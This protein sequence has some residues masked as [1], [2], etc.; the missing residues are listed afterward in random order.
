LTALFL[1]ALAA[2]AVATSPRNGAVDAT[3]SAVVTVNY[4]E[5]VNPGTVNNGTFP[6]YSSLRGRLA[7]SYAVNGSTV[8]FDPDDILLPGETVLAVATSGME[9]GGGSAVEAWSWRFTAAA[10]PGPGSFNQTGD[11]NPAAAPIQ[12]I[13]A[14]DVNGDG[15]VD[16]AAANDLLPATQNVVYLNDGTGGF[17]STKN[18]GSGVDETRAVALADVDRDGDLDAVTGNRSG[19]PNVVYLNDGAGNFTAGQR[20]FGQSADNIMDLAVAD[21]DNN[22][23]LDLIAARA[24]QPGKVYTSTDG[25]FGSGVEIGLASWGTVAVD[26]GDFDGDGDADLVLA[27][28]SSSYRNVVL[29]NNGAAAF[30]TTLS[31][32]HSSDDTRGVKFLDADQD[33]RLDIAM[34]NYGLQNRVY[35]NDGAGGVLPASLNFGTGTDHTVALVVADFNGDGYPDIGLGNRDQQN[36]VYFYDSILGYSDDANFGPADDITLGLAAADIDRDGDLDLLA[37][38]YNQQSKSYLNGGFDLFPPAVAKSG[39]SVAPY[40]TGSVVTWTITARQNGPTGDLSISDTLGPDFNYLSHSATPELTAITTGAT[41]S[42]YWPQVALGETVT[43]TLVTEL[44]GA[45]ATTPTN[46]VVFTTT[47]YLTETETTPSQ[48]QCGGQPCQY[49]PSGVQPTIYKSGVSETPY[50]AGSVVTWTVVA[51]NNG[52]VDHFYVSDEL[53]P[54]FGYISHGATPPL[55]QTFSTSPAFYGRWDTI[56]AGEWMTL[57]LVTELVTSTNG[58]TPTNSAA[59]TS[60]SY[61]TP[62]STGPVQPRCGGQPCPFKTP[63]VSLTPATQNQIG[64]PGQTIS[65]ALTLANEGSLPDTFDLTFASPWTAGLTPVSPVAVTGASSVPLTFNVT[66]PAGVI[67]GTAVS[68]YLTAT[69][70]IITAATDAAEAVSVVGLDTADGI[71][72]SPITV[73]SLL[74][75]AAGAPITLTH[76]ITNTANYTGSANLTVGLPDGW[77]GPAWFSPTLPMTLGPGLTASISIIITAPISAT[78]LPSHTVMVFLTDTFNLTPTATADIVWLN[79]DPDGD[80]DGDGILNWYEDRDGDGEYNDDDS[81]GNDWPDYLDPDDDG[82]GVWTR[83][84]MPDFSGDGNPADG[85]DTDGDGLKDYLDPNDDGDP[86]PTRDEAADP[87]GDGNPA[88]A[89]DNDGDGI[90]NY[91]D[92]DD[93]YSSSSDADGDGIPDSTEC[94]S[95][96]CRNSDSD[97]LPDWLDIDSDG[98]GLLDEYEY[99]REGNGIADDTDGDGLPNWQDPDDDGDGHSTASEQADPNG[100]GSPADAADS[101]S[102]N[103]PDY[104]DPDDDGS[105]AGGGDS[106]HD[107]IP[108]S[109]ECETGYLCP[110]SDGD[111]TP[112]YLDEDSDNDGVYDRWEYDR[113]SDGQADDTD[114]DNTPDFRDPDD[115]GDGDPTASEQADPNGDGN[116]ADAVDSDHNGLADYLDPG[117][118]PDADGDGIPD[119]TECPTAPCRDSDGDDIPD[120]QDT[121]SDDDGVLDQYECPDALLCRDTDGDDAPDYRDFDDDGDGVLTLLEEADPNDDG[122]PADATDNDGDGIPAYLDPADDGDPDGGDSDS[123]GIPDVGECPGGVPCDDNDHDSTPDYMEPVDNPDAPHLYLRISENE[124]LAWQGILSASVAI[125]LLP[126]APVETGQVLTYTVYLANS[127]GI[128]TTASL[129]TTFSTGLDVPGPVIT[130]APL[131]A[132]GAYT[133]TYARQVAATGTIT[134]TVRFEAETISGTQVITVYKSLNNGDGVYLPIITRKG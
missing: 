1:V 61:L 82:D 124:A 94:P 36:R 107:G 9:N 5:A 121:D 7:G 128:S 96:P 58:L 80:A 119:S 70:R 122:D 116:P 99:D 114:L 57:T 111:N 43:L 62:T 11:I 64:L 2:A 32:G 22:G 60:T 35:L 71:A 125:D 109:V 118:I 29:K 93:G 104:L 27:N 90:P 13:A 45:P 81:D 102:D 89:A 108:D 38:N 6:V 23:W 88:D 69:G 131:A 120:W 40:T 92:G 76:L 126:P 26:A 59:L 54:E 47:T 66:L 72:I 130:Q 12:D 52:G 133:L 123:D 55:A 14:G 44:I 75:G 41:F 10:A 79:P 68:H 51:T 49:Y 117:Q 77:P 24:G 129:T 87:N 83:H 84:E 3:G 106:D 132:G 115:D 85:R 25:F 19:H 78:L 48:P 110:D 86:Y 127:G 103:I 91:L 8:I 15:F 4:D 46:V 28:A 74:T 112:D 100:D 65:Y 31:F 37:G 50:M 56:G 105:G 42:G 20:I 18:F 67:S 98:D 63:A 97:S 30:P 101:D 53:G 39:V 21:L 95:T 134:L 17:S 16:V 33:G 34:A 73:T 113:D